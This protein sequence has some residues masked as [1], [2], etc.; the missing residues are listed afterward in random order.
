[1][2]YLLDEHLYNRI[3]PFD[4]LYEFDG[5]IARR[6]PM[7]FLLKYDIHEWLSE[8]NISY[9]LDVK[10]I[11]IKIDSVRDTGLEISK[12]TIRDDVYIEMD[13][14]SLMMFKLAWG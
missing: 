11:N 8:Q 5:P 12:Q 6:G 13:E 9:Q 14:T 3:G 1:M 4:A 2:K 10:H 7:K